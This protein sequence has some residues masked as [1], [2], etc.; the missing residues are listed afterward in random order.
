MRMVRLDTLFEVRYGH[1][2]ELNKLNQTTKENGV[3]FISRK[4]G[5]NGIDCFV[6]MISEIQPNPPGDLTR[7]L[8]GS[9]LS[10]FLQERPYY[11]AFHIACLR[12]KVFLG[13]SQLLYY[14]ACITA[15][16]YKYNYGRQANKTLKE[17][18]IPDLTDLPEWVKGTNTDILQ[19]ANCPA[20]VSITPNLNTADWRPF[21]YKDVFEIKK[22]KRLTKA[23]MTHGD[24]PF[25][26][27]IDSNNG[28]S[29]MIGE[30]PSHKANSISVSYNGSVAEAFYQPYDFWAT[31][32]V[33][34]LYPKFKNTPAISLFLC[35]LIRQ[36]KYRYN[37]GR[38]WTLEKMKKSIIRLPVKADNTPDLDFMEQYIKSLPYSSQ[39]ESL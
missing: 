8:G 24:T 6:E 23:D 31:D 18:L 19:G 37:Y 20:L 4:M 38:K 5:D 35:A 32:D 26:G 15:N 33:N 17:I 29:G 21:K 39:I 14:A 12:P 7:A 10:T 34:V 28:V 2:L 16:R 13:K 1:S 22:G 25:I 30:K 11:T 3:P 27:A 9:V 36:E